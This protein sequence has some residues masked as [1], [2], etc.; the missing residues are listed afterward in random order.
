MNPL[1]L[2]DLSHKNPLHTRKA[3]AAAPA[4]LCRRQL[5]PGSSEQRGKR[6]GRCEAHK[7]GPTRRSK[8]SAVSTGDFPSTSLEAKVLP[9]CSSTSRGERLE[10]VLWD[11]H[12]ANNRLRVMK[13]PGP[14]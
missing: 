2:H 12:D 4:R 9:R 14:A 7:T 6:F 11:G 10:G 1:E 13:I 8:S 3:R 5:W